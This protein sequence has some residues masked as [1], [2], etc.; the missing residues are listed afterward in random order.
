MQ[1]K[2]FSEFDRFFLTKSLSFEY[3]LATF[4]FSTAVIWPAEWIKQAR[5]ASRSM[6]QRTRDKVFPGDL[7]LWELF[8]M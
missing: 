2:S 8:A 7:K 1:P 6:R 5:P 4:K 3:A